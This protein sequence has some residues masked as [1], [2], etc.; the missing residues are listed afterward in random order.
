MITALLGALV[1]GEELSGMFACVG[2]C[3]A[4]SLI[5]AFVGLWW[6]GAGLLVAGSVIIGRREETGTGEQKREEDGSPTEAHAT[7]VE[8]AKSKATRRQGKTADG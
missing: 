3:H 5:R 1:F 6:V 7:A 4:V 2:W 8:G